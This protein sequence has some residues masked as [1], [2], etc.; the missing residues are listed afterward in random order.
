MLAAS[1]AGAGKN[2]T[3]F[4][5]KL[6]FL[7]VFFDQIQ[8]FTRFG[9]TSGFLLGIDKEIIHFDFEPASIRWNECN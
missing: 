6:P 3:F 2:S 9:V 8:R 1:G 4:R 7:Y 5:H